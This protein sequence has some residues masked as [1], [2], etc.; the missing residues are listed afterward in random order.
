MAGLGVA[1][2]GSTLEPVDPSDD[3]EDTEPAEDSEAED[4]Q[5]DDKKKGNLSDRIFILL[6][7]FIFIY[8]IS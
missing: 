5:D 3:S 1:C 8:F 7:L 2:A 4:A 6:N